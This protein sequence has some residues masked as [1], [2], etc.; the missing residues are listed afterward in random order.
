M[1]LG[2]AD[3]FSVG[4]LLGPLPLSLEACASP[5]HEVREKFPSAFCKMRPFCRL[6]QHP[7]RKGDQELY[8]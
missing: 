6:I 2:G 5:N 4:T 3:W 8:H 7:F 1:C